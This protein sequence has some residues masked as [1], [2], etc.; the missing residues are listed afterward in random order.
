LR[1]GVGSGVVDLRGV[2]EVDAELVLRPADDDE[3][4]AV[5]EEDGAVL[6]AGDGVISPAEVKVLVAGS[7][8]SATAVGLMAAVWPVRPPRISTFPDCSS[9]AV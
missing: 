6:G 2:G 7:N 9:V 8:S 1:E 5:V 3:D 4:S